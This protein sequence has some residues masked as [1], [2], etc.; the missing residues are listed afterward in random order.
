MTVADL[1]HSNMNGNIGWIQTALF[2]ALP[3]KPTSPKR[4]HRKNQ[5][6]FSTSNG[7]IT[8]LS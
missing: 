2:S 1:P 3:S 7:W 4:V 6:G 8:S 5:P